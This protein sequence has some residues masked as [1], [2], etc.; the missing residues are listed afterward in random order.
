[1]EK[2]MEEDF[3]SYIPGVKILSGKFDSLW[4]AFRAHGKENQMQKVNHLGCDLS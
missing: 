4:S 1:M 2:Y 3:K